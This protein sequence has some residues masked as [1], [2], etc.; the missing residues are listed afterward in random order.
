MNTLVLCCFLD[1]VCST[2]GTLGSGVTFSTQLSHVIGGPVKGEALQSSLHEDYDLDV[3]EDHSGGPGTEGTIHVLQEAKKKT[4]GKG[5]KK[6]KHKGK[7]T[8]VFIPEHSSFRSGQTSGTL[9]EL[10]VFSSAHT[11]TEDPCTSS[12]W[13]FC[14]HGNCKYNEDL[15]EPV[16]VCM[17]GFD[18]ERCGIQLLETWKN[19][20]DMADSKAEVD[21]TILVIIAVL[22]AITSCAAI[23]I[24]SCT[25]GFSYRTRKNFLAAYLDTGTEKEKLQKRICDI[26]V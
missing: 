2:L 5:K 18:G 4:K 23:L 20:K 9:E 17:K 7:T 21:Q 25:H 11:T 26:T 10:T 14:I 15:R 19:G 1:L 16:C 3:E 22:L 24:L 12:H 6:N 13:G 8:R